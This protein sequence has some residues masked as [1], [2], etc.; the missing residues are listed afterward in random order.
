MQYFGIYI[1]NLAHKIT[2]PR[3]FTFVDVHLIFIEAIKL[4]AIIAIPIVVV[5]LTAGLAG[6]FA[7]GGLI[8]SGEGFKPK[9]DKFNPAKNIKKI[10]GLDSVVNLLKSTLETD[11]FVVCRLRR[12][13]AGRRNRADFVQRADSN[14]RVKSRFD[15]FQP[16]LQ[17]RFGDA[18]YLLLPITVIRSIN[19]KNR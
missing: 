12:F 18:R 3:A 5:S 14:H 17:M 10:F 16:F 6:N 4:L 13:I 1:N 19:T 15:A 7:Q 8:L 11:Y 9:A 2:D